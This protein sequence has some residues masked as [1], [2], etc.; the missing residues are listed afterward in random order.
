MS[1]DQQPDQAIDFLIKRAEYSAR[2]AGLHRKG[3][4]FG[5][6]IALYRDAYKIL[7]K[8][9]ENRPDDFII[10]KKMD[11]VKAQ[12]DEARGCISRAT[13]SNRGTNSNSRRYGSSRRNSS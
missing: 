7:E 2:Q 10:K 1:D 8:A 6:A 11:E 4:E 3:N 13:A 9:L 12:F 5:K